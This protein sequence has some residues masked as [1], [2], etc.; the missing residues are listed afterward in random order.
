MV[1]KLQ[2]NATQLLVF[3]YWPCESQFCTFLTCLSSLGFIS[4]IALLWLECL[5]LNSV[6][7]AY[8]SHFF[9]IYFLLFSSKTHPKFSVMFSGRNAQSSSFHRPFLV[10]KELGKSFLSLKSDSV[11]ISMV[12]FCIVYDELSSTHPTKGAK[13]VRWKF[14]EKSFDPW[15]VRRTS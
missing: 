6:E 10:M 15:Y 3:D 13:V 9:K 5:F 2:P 4:G 12:T 14:F 1:R 7:T 8:Y 11:W